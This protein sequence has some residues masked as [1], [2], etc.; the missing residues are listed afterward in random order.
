MVS[1]VRDKE[2]ALRMPRFGIGSIMGLVAIVALDFWVFRVG[3]QDLRPAIDRYWSLTP[4]DLITKREMLARGALPMANILAIG[5]L[6][7]L[8]RRGSHPSLPGFEAVGA[9]ALVAY[10]CWAV[11][12]FPRQHRFNDL[13]DL[14][15]HHWLIPEFIGSRHALRQVAISVVLVLPQLGLA[16][17][18]GFLC[19]K[20]RNAQSQTRGETE[21]SGGPDRITSQASD[22]R[23]ISTS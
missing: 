13:S 9:L 1:N 12:V 22:T 3:Y 5:L 11:F 15:R 7:G 18:G 19:R 6:V 20:L 4:N 8:R 14:I 17:A 16:L 10:S 2:V 21:Q 23:A